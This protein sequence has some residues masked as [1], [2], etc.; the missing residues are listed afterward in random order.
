MKQLKHLNICYNSKIINNEINNYLTSNWDNLSNYSKEDELLDLIEKKKINILITDYNF[1]LLKKVRNKNHDIQILAVLEELKK[2]YL[3]QSLELEYIKLLKDFN[4]QVD[5]TSTLLE[6][7]KNLDSRKSNI[8]TLKNDFIFD[9]YNKSLFK[10]E[11][12]VPLSNKEVALL[13]LLIQNENKV[14]TYEDI[15]KN[16]WNE[17]MSQDVLRTI[18]KQ[19]RKKT[20]KELIK[21]VS[22]IGY[23]LDL[24]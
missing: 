19:L 20:Y 21:N 1:E 2:D 17:N 3:V 22:G 13:D 6:C 12:I 5:F 16:I 7:Q 24:I 23:R 10:D 4:S 9:K 11:E 15:D 14:L 8:V 18:I